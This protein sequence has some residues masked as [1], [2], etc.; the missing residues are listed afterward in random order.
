VARYQLGHPLYAGRRATF[1]LD[2]RQYLVAG[3]GTKLTASRYPDKARHESTKQEVFSCFRVF[4][5]F[6][7]RAFVACW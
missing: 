4:V 3:T 6:S 1:M 7:F 2:N 5:A